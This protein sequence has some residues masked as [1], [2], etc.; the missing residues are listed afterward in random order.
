MGRLELLAVLYSLEKL[1]ESDKPEKANENAL[2]VIRKVI[3]EA[4]TSPKQT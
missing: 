3:K 4:E 1:L 2:E